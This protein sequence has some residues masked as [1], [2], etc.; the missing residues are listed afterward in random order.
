MAIETL[1]EDQYAFYLQD[2]QGRP[3]GQAEAEAEYAFRESGGVYRENG[4]IK[5]GTPPTSN[6]GGA[7]ETFGPYQEGQEP[8]GFVS[9]DSSD[10]TQ[11]SDD[12]AN[13][14][15][16][17]TFDTT[18]NTNMAEGTGQQIITGSPQNL[19]ET[20]VVDY[21]GVQ[22][23]D[24][25]LQPDMKMEDQFKEIEIKD[26]ELQDYTNLED[27]DPTVTT[28][29]TGEA[30]T[31]A[32]PDLADTQL[33]ELTEAGLVDRPDLAKTSAV[34]VSDQLVDTEAARGESVCLCRA[35]PSRTG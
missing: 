33:A 20:N 27:A 1:T 4:K 13:E 16:V 30:E 2:V 18:G 10:I 31:V 26:T 3:R 14:M 24:P 25:T 7:G 21:M 12:L 23:A 5:V 9:G 19:N 32:A 28:P 6:T 34:S 11:V 17:E 22:A 15:G 8:E 35:D 29:V